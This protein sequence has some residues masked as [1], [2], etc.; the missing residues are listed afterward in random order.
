M[1]DDCGP[2]GNEVGTVAFFVAVGPERLP[3]RGQ[4]QISQPLV[5][6]MRVL[7]SAS[8]HISYIPQA[9]ECPLLALPINLRD[10]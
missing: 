7:S 2:D 8:I 10:L 5:M 9:I 6:F 1:P 3:P 4:R